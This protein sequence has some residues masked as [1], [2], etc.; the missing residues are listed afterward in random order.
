M[1]KE[2]RFALER[3]RSMFQRSIVF[4]DMVAAIR[5]RKLFKALEIVIKQP[6]I[7]ILVTAII[8]KL[9]KANILYRRWQAAAR[10][11]SIIEAPAGRAV[12]VR[13][14]GLTCG[15]CRSEMPAS[16]KLN[17]EKL[18]LPLVTVNADRVQDARLRRHKTFSPYPP[19]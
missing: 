3:R 12:I 10:T 4:Q 13:F 19:A 9:L 18:D 5:E 8:L 11:R 15:P 14:W 16:G 1:T 2:A 6:F 17:A 7:L